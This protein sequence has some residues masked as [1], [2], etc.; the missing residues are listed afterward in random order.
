MKK[1]VFLLVAIFCLSFS[2]D[3][4]ACDKEASREV[5]TMLKDMATWYEKDGRIIF[6]WGNDWDHA[7]PE[8]RLTPIFTGHL[9]V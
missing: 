5:Q 3:V 7:T 2:L 4:F 8:Q 9:T 6:K 1:L